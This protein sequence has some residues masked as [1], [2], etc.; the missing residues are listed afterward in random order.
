VIEDLEREHEFRAAL[1]SSVKAGNRLAQR[2]ERLETGTIIRIAAAVIVVGL[3]STAILPSILTRNPVASSTV[4]LTTPPAP[5]PAA[6]AQTE[7][8]V[9]TQPVTAPRPESPPAV[10]PPVPAPAA[11][12]TTTVAKAPPVLRGSN[13]PDAQSEARA[14]TQVAAPNAGKADG[15]LTLTA[16]EK[17]AVTRGLQELEKQAAVTTPAPPR[18]R[19]SARPQL[20]DEEKAAIERGLRELEKAEQAKQ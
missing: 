14:A 10:A 17:A 1:A 5:A 9:S 15:G 4:T 19:A 13:T 20:T 6:P 8:A 12:E 7:Q 3:G 2:H 11:K 16:A 18:P